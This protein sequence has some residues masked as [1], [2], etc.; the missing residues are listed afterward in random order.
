MSDYQWKQNC[1]EAWY[2]EFDVSFADLYPNHPCLTNDKE[3]FLPHP[4][5]CHW[6]YNCSNFLGLLQTP[7]AV[8]EGWDVFTSE[9]PYPQLFSDTAFRCQ[10]YS[11]VDCGKR[12]LQLDPCQLLSAFEPNSSLQNI[13][14]Q[15]MR[16]V[17][18]KS[19]WV[20]GLANQWVCDVCG[21]TM[22]NMLCIW[23]FNE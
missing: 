16:D 15:W 12:Q 13:C 4:R 23:Q 20:M 22:K 7:G 11:N 5:N 1:S 10:N 14:H 17:S 2:S 6:F 3:Y 21:R 19:V 18:G 9:C 8:P